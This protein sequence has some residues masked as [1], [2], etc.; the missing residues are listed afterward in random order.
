[1]T[2]QMKSYNEKKNIANEFIQKINPYE[3][4]KPLK[5]DLRGYASYV[6]ENRLTANE[7]TPKLLDMF[8]KK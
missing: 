2:G 4:G 7:I 6:K 3:T 5:F 1:M 8:V